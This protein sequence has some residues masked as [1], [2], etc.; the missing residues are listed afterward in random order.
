MYGTVT[1]SAEVIKLSKLETNSLSNNYQH[2]TYRYRL[3]GAKL[4]RYQL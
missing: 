1:A 3:L 4:V 2:V